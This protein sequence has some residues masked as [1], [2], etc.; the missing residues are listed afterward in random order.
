MS[1]TKM[2][3]MD[4][5][6]AVRDKAKLS[7]SDFS[8]SIAIKLKP[9]KIKFQLIA[10]DCEHLFRPRTQHMI[11]TI[12]DEVDPNE[13]WLVADCKGEGCPVCIAANAFKKSG[14]TTVEEVNRIYNVKF[15][16]K[17]LHAL[18]TQPEHYLLC[19]RVLVD[20]ADDGSY[21]PKNY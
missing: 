15:P 17:N 5:L 6:N 20:Q 16:Y 21:L 2:S 4:M 9:G 19:A 8:K 1:K 18:F 13:K 3:P 10:A 14:V 12:P 7:D 11:P